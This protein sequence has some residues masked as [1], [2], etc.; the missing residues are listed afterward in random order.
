MACSSGSSPAY[1]SYH[2]NALICFHALLDPK[3]KARQD[4]KQ[5]KSQAPKIAGGV[6]AGLFIIALV[7]VI[8]YVIYRKKKNTTIPYDKQ[9][10]YNDDTVDF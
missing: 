5:S 7:L 9:I 8:A 1:E 6:I 4:K 2:F 10:L 3:A